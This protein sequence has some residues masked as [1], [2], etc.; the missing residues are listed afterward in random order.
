MNITEKNDVL[1]NK[2]WFRPKVFLNYADR[3]YVSNEGGKMIVFKIVKTKEYGLDVYVVYAAGSKL[4]TFLS[5]TLA[6]SYI[7]RNFG[8]YYK[9][10]IVME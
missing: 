9:L 5:E 4:T 3:Y 2:Y 7:Q 8:G 1:Q 10:D 6:Y